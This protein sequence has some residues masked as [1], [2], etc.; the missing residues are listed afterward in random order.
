MTQCASEREHPVKGLGWTPPDPVPL[1]I[2]T[3]RLVLRG[4]ELSD[5]EP[6]FEQISKWRSTLAPWVSWAAT[7]HKDVVETSEWVAGQILASRV[8]STQPHRGLLITDRAT[9]AIVGG[10]GVHDIRPDTA[11]CET[12]YWVAGDRRGQGIAGEACRHTI[13]WALR[14]KDAGGLGLRRV[15]IYCSS[16]NAASMRVIEKLGVR[17][18]VV[19][20]EDYF[21]DGIGLTDRIG[22]GVMA[23][24]WDV[25]E[26]QLRTTSNRAQTGR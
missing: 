11:S 1:R 16:A 3:P 7:R 18:E 12:G 19:Q 6:L 4:Y 10:T 21:L 5:I 20:R 2:E 22:W 15:R 26:H 13:S 25:G 17:R 24:E 8:G 9:G 14:A 23:E